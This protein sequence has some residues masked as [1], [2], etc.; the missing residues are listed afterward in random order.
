METREFFKSDGSSQPL[1]PLL[2]TEFGVAVLAPV[3]Q[4]SGYTVAGATPNTRLQNVST[5]V[6]H[7]KGTLLALKNNGDIEYQVFYLSME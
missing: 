5:D 6:N 1:S 4:S 3:P 7:S 2:F